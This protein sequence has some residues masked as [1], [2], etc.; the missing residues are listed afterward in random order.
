MIRRIAFAL[1]IFSIAAFCMFSVANEKD[2]RPK[3]VP[4]P[5]PVLPDPPK[6]PP[7]LIKVE[8]D[9]TAYSGQWQIDLISAR[10]AP[11]EYTRKTVSGLK[12]HELGDRLIVKVRITNGGSAPMTYI[13]WH[14]IK[15]S[16]SAKD[17]NKKSYSLWKGETGSKA[18]GGL[19][20]K[21]D[22]SPKKSIEDVI[23]FEV[24][25]F[26]SQEIGIA[27][28]AEAFK[29]NGL[30]YFKFGRSFFDDEPAWRKQVTKKFDVAKAAHA[31]IV[32]KMIADHDKQILIA[33]A[34]Y[35]ALPMKIE[36][37]RLAKIAAAKEAKEKSEREAKAVKEKAD[38][39]A[40]ERS[41][42]TAMIGVLKI[43]ILSGGVGKV[44]VEDDIRRDSGPSTKKLTWIKIRITNTSEKSLK[45]YD[46]W[47]GKDFGTSH[48][49]LKDDLDNSYPRITWRLGQKASGQLKA[50][51][52]V[53]PEGSITDVLIFDAPIE[54][55]D[56]FTLKMPGANIG[57]SGTVTMRFSRKLLS[58]N[59]D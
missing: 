51:T 26:E 21:T 27:L 49:S 20:Y 37:E 25:A 55:A 28:S 56:S 34:E 24:P 59:Y 14:T 46:P 1:V 42:Q 43:E 47:T 13:P 52:R 36:Q 58:S 12:K 50:R 41:E 54:K 5:P 45:Y 6:Q 2:A 22:V 33:K 3:F 57:E 19:N 29:K 23:A 35:D 18:D 4:P 11:F 53:E 7:P 8:R 38:L 10:I 9:L 39:D 16:G 30:L 15:D 31:A 44:T 48:A 17:E 40:K 32:A